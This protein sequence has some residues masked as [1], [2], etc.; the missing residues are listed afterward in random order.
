ME[1]DL[2]IYFICPTNKYAT[3]G[4]KQMYRQVEVLNDNG[5]NARILHKWHGNREKWLQNNPPISY[6][7]YIFKQIK[8]KANSK[9]INIFR[10]LT[11]FFLKMISKKIGSNSILVFPEFYGLNAHKITPNLPR[12]I[13]NQNCYYTFDHSDNF[14]LQNNTYT[15]DKTLAVITVSE[16]SQSYLKYIFP[17]IPIHKLRLGINN[18]LFFYSK[19]KK[20]QIC[21]MPRKLSHDISQVI[22]ILRLRGMDSSWNLVPIEDKSEKEVAQIM[23]ESSIFLSFNHREGFGLP[24]AE[25]MAC[26]CI[27]VGYIGRGGAEYFKPEFSYSVEEGDIIG[28][29]NKII[30]VINLFE[31]NVDLVTVQRKQA[32]DFILNNYS[33]NNEISDVVDVWKNTLKN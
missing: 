3:G 30:Y 5:I 22:N 32:S 13:F 21:F 15:D 31:T 23:R 9:S 7:P 4:V 17:K 18:E 16:D 26:G 27:V 2:I 33:I 14:D 10:R 20:K 12:V 11:L 24:P 6:S 8:Y 1:Q 19:E 29:V 25:A 28:Y